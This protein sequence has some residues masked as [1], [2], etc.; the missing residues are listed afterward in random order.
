MLE[1]TLKPIETFTPLY[2]DKKSQASKKKTKIGIFFILSIYIEAKMSYHVW[3]RIL[4]K[5]E[6]K[7]EF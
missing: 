3:Y 2:I 7:E 1:L 6:K 5:S 4:Q